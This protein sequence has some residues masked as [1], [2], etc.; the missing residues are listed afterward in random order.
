MEQPLG[1]THSADGRMKRPLTESDIERKVRAYCRWTCAVK[2]KVPE[3]RRNVPFSVM[4][5]NVLAQENLDNHPE[6][7][8]H[9]NP[10]HL[11]WSFRRERII[12]YVKLCACEIICLQE[13]QEEH[14][15]QYIGPVLR[16]D[17]YNFTYI[18]KT[19]EKVEG[20][21]I[22][23][24][25][26]LFKLEAVKFVE[27]RVPGCRVMTR[28][29][30][31]LV[32]MLSVVRNP[33]VKLVVATTHLLFNPRRG[34]MKLAQ[35]RYLLAE[36]EEMAY[37]GTCEKEP[38]NPVYMPI[39]LC[40]DLN[41]TPFCPLYNF[42]VE[43]R[44]SLD[45]LTH[46]EIGGKSGGPLISAEEIRAG[47]LLPC[48][49]HK[50]QFTMRYHLDPVLVMER[51]RVNK[52]VYHMLGKFK[53]CYSHR[54]R[55]APEVTAYSD[56]PGTVDYMFFQRSSLLTHVSMMNVMTLS[57]LEKIGG[58][59]NAFMG[60]DHLPLVARFVLRPIP[61]DVLATGLP[62]CAGD[63]KASLA[64]CVTNRRHRPRFASGRNADGVVVK[65]GSLWP[66]A[67]HSSRSAITVFS[68]ASARSFTTNSLTRT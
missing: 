23:W 46:G 60:S 61:E 62:L 24:Q 55:D 27:M 44:L 58:L 37:L 6:L 47:G 4:S 18:K 10:D 32:V 51:E 59:P 50:L 56:D 28:D 20:C 9:C 40:G 13:V 43:G 11:A 57:E 1:S 33:R 54:K 42:I 67:S 30:V 15:Y 2:K 26:G 64:I 19:G 17:G 31:G 35:L 63:L 53:S 29:N 48:T 5:Y 12:N 8:R 22:F 38:M 65:G 36:V 66:N 68:A 41:M 52:I 45:G 21:A 39:L 14:L 49:M 16:E 25:V 7:Y 34:E 3:K